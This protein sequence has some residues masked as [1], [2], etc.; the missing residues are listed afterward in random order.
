MKSILIYH[1]CNELDYD[2]QNKSLFYRHSSLIQEGFIHCSFKDQVEIVLTRYFKGVKDLYILTI[3]P[4]LLLSP[5]KEEYS[6][7]NELYPHVY[8]E[9]NKGAI[10]KVESVMS[11]QLHNSNF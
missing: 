9:I 11:Y 5:L 2:S 1:I 6:T 8:G 7:N 4:T 3:D 10:I